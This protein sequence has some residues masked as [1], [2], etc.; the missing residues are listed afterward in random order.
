LLDHYSPAPSSPGLHSPTR[1]DKALACPLLDNE[2]IEE[3]K[4]GD[5]QSGSSFSTDDTDMSNMSYVTEGTG[6]NC[7]LLLILTKSSYRL[8][9]RWRPRHLPCKL[10][11]PGFAIRIWYP[12]GPYQARIF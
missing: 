10:G 9:L 5:S 11:E 4:D 3:N 1:R 8:M 7:T 2:A 12:D 6:I